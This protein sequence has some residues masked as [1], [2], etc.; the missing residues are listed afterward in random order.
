MRRASVDQRSRKD[1]SEKTTCMMREK[2]AR[3]W[4]VNLG[5]ILAEET[6]GGEAPRH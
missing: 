5:T 1:F 6:A 3:S 2:G 4:K